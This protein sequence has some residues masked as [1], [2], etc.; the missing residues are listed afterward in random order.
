MLRRRGGADRLLATV[1]FTDIVG[2]TERAGELG[3]RAWKRLLERH[4]AI[5][6]REL[7]RFAGR[8]LDTAGDGFFVMFERPAQ[9]ID[10]AWAVMDAL[11]PLDLQIRASVHMGEVEVMGGKVGG[12][13][14]HAASRVLGLAQPGQ[15]YVTGIVRDV[16]AG[17][18]IS[19][20][21]RGV[22][23]L[24]GVPGEWRVFAVEETARDRALPLEPPAEPTDVRHNWPLTIAVV[25]AVAVIAAGG[26]MLGLA[27]LSRPVS[28][29]PH[30]NS[31]VQLGAAGAVL[32]LAEVNDPT[33][34]TVDDSVLW[35][36]SAGGRN[37][38]RVDPTTGAATPIG[39]PATPTGL[40]ATDGAIWITTGFGSA[41]G[42]AGV[43]RVGVSSLAHEVTIPVG[44]GA[45]GIAATDDALW[46]TNRVRNTLTRIDLTTRLVT[47][48]IDVGEQ[49]E[50]VAVG[51]GSI[52]VANAI[53]RTI[54]RID[55]AT[56][57]RT[58]EIAIVDA[59]HDLAFGFG[60]L[61]VTS[62]L[63]RS[64]TV[65]DTATN[66]IQ[67]TLDVGG[68][69]RGITAGADSVWVAIGEG[70]A[71]RIDPVSPSEMQTI[72]LAG[73]PH[74]V[75]A[76]GDGAWVSIRE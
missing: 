22:H 28:I 47:G 76:H 56:M 6:R 12:I 20:S 7:K 21:E 17:S 5:V 63:D 13:A 3:D 14:V 51:D 34:M 53:D 66:S 11:R 75:A 33:E 67:Q 49:P 62:A 73:A 74:D 41:S 9:A 54:W 59:P 16:V 48:E 44:A 45:E 39:L 43:L 50:A 37:L 65:L 69:A 70:S 2:A 46:V 64:V 27:T 10:C 55:P 71:L 32:T 38:L 57:T 35:V 31:V 8:E 52:W 18:D 72:V 40:V 61:W 26:T 68:A 60:R 23:E 4:N 25:V 42:D 1:M 36:L 24:R 58:A 19:F 15:I 29:I 30:P